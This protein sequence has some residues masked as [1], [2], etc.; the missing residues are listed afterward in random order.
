MICTFIGGLERPGKLTRILGPWVRLTMDDSHLEFT[1]RFRWLARLFGPWRLERSVIREVYQG[2]ESLIAPWVT[3]NF[4]G[5]ENMPWSFLAWQQGVLEAAE[6]LG[7][8]V[9]RDD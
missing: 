4:L 6:K 5:E 7:Y 1:L 8:P 9:R 2:R 3:V